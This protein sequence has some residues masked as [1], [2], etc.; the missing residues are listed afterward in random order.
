MKAGLAGYPIE[1][2]LSV[3]IHGAAYRD[4]GVDIDYQLYPTTLDQLDD[5][6]ASLDES[7][8]GLSITM[9]LK[10][11]IIDKLDFVDG[12]AKTVGAV[13]TVC[14]Q[15]TGGQLVGFNTD[16]YGIAQAVRESGEISTPSAIILGSRA[17][18]SSSLA[19]I[20]ELGIKEHITLAARN[21]GGP[22]SA[23]AAATRMDLSPSLVKLTDNIVGAL[24]GTGLL[25][26]TLPT[27][28]ADTLANQIDEALPDLSRL[29]VLDV[30]Y[31]PWPSRLVAAAEARG[32]RIVPGWSMLLHQA[33]SQVRLFSNKTPDVGVMREALLEE[34]ARR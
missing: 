20:V 31:H 14:Y 22:G 4:L 33:V 3:A 10:Q 12:L 6:L 16:V 30:N 24:P 11:A 13:N 2:S 5:L 17:T 29:T 8:A 19:A 28:V 18:A 26:S 9:P 21:H 23:V 7:W 1:H 32:A 34:L 27:G 15:P 25:I